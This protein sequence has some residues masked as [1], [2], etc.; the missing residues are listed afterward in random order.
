MGSKPTYQFI[1]PSCASKGEIPW[2]GPHDE[3]RC[4]ACGAA[5][6]P[7]S[8]PR[9]EPGVLVVEEEEDEAAPDAGPPMSASGASPP[10]AGR[11]TSARDGAGRRKTQA[12]EPV[13]EPKPWILGSLLLPVAARFLLS[14]PVAARWLVLSVTLVV[15]CLL[16]RR[17]VPGSEWNNE[18][19]AMDWLVFLGSYGLG[20]LWSLAWLVAA[21]GIWLSILRDS[22]AGLDDVENWPDA[23]LLDS[24]AESIY[25]INALF[26][27]ALPGFAVVQVAGAGWGW[28]LGSVLMLFPVILLSM[29]D[30][31]SSFTPLTATVFV[32]LLAS[33]LGWLLFFTQSI[34]LAWVGRWVLGLVWEYGDLGSLAAGCCVAVGLSLLYFRMLGRLAWYAGVSSPPNRP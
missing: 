6:L 1:C 29:L 13:E 19:F 21:N 14:L 23:F 8:R 32:S 22:A 11:S 10:A 4:P 30:A 25:L 15:P 26:L 31:G 34:L 3:C 7:P 33:V 20:V 24:V 12:A 17:E 18:A 5:F 16:L 28:V 2:P 27:A 9:V